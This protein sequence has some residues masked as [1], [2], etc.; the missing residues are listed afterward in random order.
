MAVIA[1]TAHSQSS[2]QSAFD[3]YS[4]SINSKFDNYKKQIDKRYSDYLRGIW[5]KY[6]AYNPLSVPKDD[7][8]PVVY[9]K[10]KPGIDEIPIKDKDVITITTPEPAP[11]P[12]PSPSPTVLPKADVTF[13][14]TTIEVSHPQKLPTLNGISND[15]LADAWNA[16]TDGEFDSTIADCQAYKQ[17]FKLCDWAYVNMLDEVS[18]AIFQNDKRMAKLFFAFLLDSTGYDMRLGKTAQD[19][20]VL[21]SCEH[22]VFK[23]TYFIID[24]K[25]FY[26]FTKNSDVKNMQIC[27]TPGR[28]KR[29]MS[30]Y[31]NSEQQ[32]TDTPIKTRTI[33]STYGTPVEVKIS[34]S[35]NML[36]FYTSYPTS[37]INGDFMTRWAMYAQTPME[38]LTREPLYEQLKKYIAGK[39]QI[40]AANILLNFVQ[41]GLVYKYDDEVWGEDRAFFGEESLY[42][43]YCDC[44]DRSILFSHLVRDLLGLEVGLVYTPGHL[45][46]VVNFTEPTSGTYMMVGNKKFT[47]CEPT[48]T[49]GAKV[50]WSAYKP[51]APDNKLILLSKIKY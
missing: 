16:F 42:Y 39:S 11:E 18:K 47:V 50:G 9:D 4:Q 35:Q 36:D 46:T 51:D 34:V 6:D 15:N 29:S 20:I 2:K 41:T 28:N 3:K 5:E 26:A 48:C 37:A 1:I 38:A 23:Y 21:L 12:M 24:G 33:K 14:N 49:N 43:P 7:V 25:K 13:F 19:I 8:E 17:K 10:D 32:F 30:L 40:Q 44:E 45:F 22:T 31:I 27:S